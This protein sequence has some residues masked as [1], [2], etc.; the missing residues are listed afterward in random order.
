[1][2]K[3][4][5]IE[6]QVN[7][8]ISFVKVQE[9]KIYEILCEFDILKDQAGIALRTELYQDIAELIAKPTSSN[10]K[11]IKTR[12]Y[13]AFI[14]T[15]SR[16]IKQTLSREDPL[17]QELTDKIKPL[18]DEVNAKSEQVGKLFL[19]E[20]KLDIINTL[21]DIVNM[22]DI[23]EA[24]EKM[25]GGKQKYSCV[26][27]CTDIL[28]HYDPLEFDCEGLKRTTI[29]TILALGISG[30]ELPH[31]ILRTQRYKTIDDLEQFIYEGFEIIH[32]DKN[33]ILPDRESKKFKSMIDDLW[34]TISELA[35]SQM[36][37]GTEI[38]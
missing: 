5:E 38:T 12:I 35:D 21:A 8:L 23:G 30:I 28:N 22:D 26:R 37:T 3:L 1:M 17:Y 13:C 29:Y 33:T 7:E 11:N 9:R 15:E 36:E 16:G 25:V 34:S 32:R 18:I 14:A 6:K 20:I 4:R 31:R 24:N 10:E 27:K 19:D 2:G